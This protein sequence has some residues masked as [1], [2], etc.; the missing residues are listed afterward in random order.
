MLSPPASSADVRSRMQRQGRRD[1]APEIQLR[2]QL[3]ALGFR[4]RIHARP[5]AG[6]R[7]EADVLFR[8]AKVAVF[9]DG[10]YWHGCPECNA[11]RKRKSNASYWTSKIERNRARDL[12]T[13]QRFEQCGWAVVRVWEHQDSFEAATRIAE[14]VRGS[15]RKGRLS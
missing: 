15:R 2:K 10:C 7:R 6:L 5:I 11:G 1:T 9:V 13:T 8:S 3:Y 12:D 4:Y 14:L